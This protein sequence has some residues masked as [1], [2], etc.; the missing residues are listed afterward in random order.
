ML[1]GEAISPVDVFFTLPNQLTG[2]LYINVFLFG[3]YGLFLIGGTLYQ[4]RLRSASMYASFSTFLVT[5]LLV[6]LGRF[7][8]EPIAGGTQLIP[9]TIVL[10]GN[11]LWNYLSSGGL[12]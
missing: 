11:L 6:L 7:T 2:G 8:S 3:V 1:P 5:F 10:M 9:V 4:Q 12:R